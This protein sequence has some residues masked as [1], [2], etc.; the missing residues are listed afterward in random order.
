MVG[1]AEQKSKIAAIPNKYKDTLNDLIDSSDIESPDRPQ[2][3]DRP[4]LI[5]KRSYN[6]PKFKGGSPSL[7][8]EDCLDEY[9]P[10]ILLE[11]V[12]KI[13]AS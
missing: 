5:D 13:R 2:S 11:P 7:C 10:I 12:S 4:G 8:E 6:L 3:L 9:I 1:G